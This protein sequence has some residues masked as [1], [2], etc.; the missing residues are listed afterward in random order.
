[1]SQCISHRSF[2]AI[3]S[4]AVPFLIVLT[5]SLLAFQ[6][7]ASGEVRA[8]AAQI[9]ITPPAGTPSAGYGDRMGQGM[10]GVHDPLL[11]T[12]LVLDNGEKMIAFVGVDHLGFGEAMVG[13]VEQGVH[14]NPATA[15]CEVYLGSS[16]THSGGGAYFDI[17]GLGA[18]LA[19]EFDSAIYQSYIDGAVRSVV[20]AAEKLEPAKAGVGYGHAPNMNSYR[21]DWPPNVE[22][23]RR[24][25]G[26]QSNPGGRRAPSRAIQFRGPSHRPERTKHA[27]LR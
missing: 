3:W 13:A 18:R 17:P 14:A 23:P 26:A 21:G 4:R 11:A 15:A 8:G 25:G 16:H 2:T 20:E 9:D 1:M 5:G 7:P 22:T 10:E 12:A 6:T 24:S 19:G 27:F